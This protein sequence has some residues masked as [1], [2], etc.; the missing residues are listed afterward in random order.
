MKITTALATTLTITLL[1][2]PAL[3][4]KADSSA[5]VKMDM[6]PGLWK[7]RT[8][9]TSQG[10]EV[11]KAM[12]E[13]KKQLASMPADQRKMM[14]EMM[15]RQGIE[16]SDA[17]KPTITTNACVTREEIERG[18]LPTPE[19]DC[20]QEIVKES[21]NTFKIN[22]SCSGKP[23]LSGTGELKFTDPKN[24]TSR[25]DLAAQQDGKE[26]AV[27]MAQTG[28]WVSADCGDVKPAKDERPKP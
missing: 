21:K 3:A 22:L 6:A 5:S 13:M 1:S 17:G 12:Q 24:Y 4:A 9:M 20:Q 26:E 14:E 28:K 19:E 11:D 8:T 15:A 10:G 2:A 27:T 25:F 7:Y 18:Q 16:V 23:S